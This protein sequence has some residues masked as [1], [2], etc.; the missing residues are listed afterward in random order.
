MLG[1][2]LAFAASA[3]AAAVIEITA[4]T[5]ENAP[6]GYLPGTTVDFEVA[7]T[8]D[9]PDPIYLSLLTLDFSQSSPEL[10]F[11]GP[12]DWPLDP[13]GHPMGNGREEFVLAVDPA[14]HP[15]YSLF[16]DYPLAN[17]TLNGTFP[18][19]PSPWMLKLPEAGAGSLVAGHGTV[20]LP[21]DAPMYSEFIV[22][23]LNTAAPDLDWGARIDFSWSNPQTWHSTA[24]EG[25]QWLITGDSLV[26]TVV[27]EP[28]TLV[29]LALGAAALMTKRRTQGGTRG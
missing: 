24:P 26:L 17:A 25:S 16:P 23:A 28:G 1:S 12:D 10:A 7:M 21:Q 8:S 11:T 3:H 20:V 18:I 13:A 9:S 5:P 14:R 15:F 27:P 2:L 22:D 4:L 29:L 6:G 19:D